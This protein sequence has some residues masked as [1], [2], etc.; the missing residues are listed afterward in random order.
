MTYTIKKIDHIQL[1]APR[2][3]E[4]QAR[5]FFK[6]ILGLEEEEKPEELKQNGGVWFVLGEVHLHIGIEEPFSPASKAHPAFE[7]NNL[8]G[9]KQ[10]LLD[11]GIAVKEDGRLPGAKRF[12]VSDPF[13]NRLEFLEWLE[14]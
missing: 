8:D 7:V 5:E 11:S 1:A 10:R 14:R 9:L 6:G 13:G 2:G 4:E 3:S 12:Y